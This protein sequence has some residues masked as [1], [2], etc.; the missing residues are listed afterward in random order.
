MKNFNFRWKFKGEIR[1][2]WNLG[3]GIWCLCFALLCQSNVSAQSEDFELW[4]GIELEKDWGKK[5]TFSFEEQ[6][7]L[8]NNV[9][10][11]K[12][13]FLDG[14]VRYK[15]FKQ[16]RISLG[17]RYTLR[18]RS[19]TQRLYTDLS[20]KPDKKWWVEP[21]FRLR[22]QE[23]YKRGDL[24]ERTVRPKLSLKSGIKPLK[25]DL[26]LAG[27]LFYELSPEGSDFNRYRLVLG[28]SRPLAA[29]SSVTLNYLFQE[30]FNV[31]NPLTSSVISLSYSIVLNEY[32]LAARR[33]LPR[34]KR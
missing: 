7:R 12:S 19:R 22:Y 14:G 6:V 10:Q 8:N 2:N 31:R 11:F 34:V 23:N 16:A 15:M 13:A 3:I 5:L 30:E 32:D 29:R 21:V 17:Y 1:P 9:A 27:E 25:L 20:L 26:S 18:S 4:K 24:P 33:R 28:F